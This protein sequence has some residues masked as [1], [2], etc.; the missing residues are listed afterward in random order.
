MKDPQDNA[1]LEG[2]GF[3]DENL[4]WTGG[5]GDKEFRADLRAK[6]TTAG[7]PGADANHVGKRLNR[8]RFIRE[9]ALVGYASGDT[10]Y[11]YSTAPAALAPQPLAATPS[12]ANEIRT[13]LPVRIPIDPSPGAPSVRVDV[14]D[15]FG[16]HLA[17]P[18]DEATPQPGPREITWSGETE[19]G[20][21]GGRRHLHLPRHDG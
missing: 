5:W 18:L 15:R 9:P 6:R 2:I 13:R 3:L 20:G 17:T 1:N 11:K 19:S 14:W 16:E 7:K 10:V 4:G 12:D 21:R 8:F